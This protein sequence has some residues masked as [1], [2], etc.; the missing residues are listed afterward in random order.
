MTF[1][2]SIKSCF[3]KYAEFTG[4]ASRS[5]FWYFTLFYLVVY[6]VL[7]GIGSACDSTFFMILAGLFSLGCLLP[8]LSVAVR[9]MHDIGKGGGWIFISFIPLIGSIW[10]IVLACQD[11]EPGANR[12]GANPN[13]YGPTPDSF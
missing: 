4:R 11:S 7:Y 5:E 10:F 3:S 12:F 1:S 13:V 2:E 6:G 8:S 9:R